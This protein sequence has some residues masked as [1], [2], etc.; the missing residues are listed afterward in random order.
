VIPTTST[1]SF[2]WLTSSP[3]IEQQSLFLLSMAMRF[4]T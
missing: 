2:L 1:V 3:K 4:A